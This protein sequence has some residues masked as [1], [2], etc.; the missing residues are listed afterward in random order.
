VDASILFYENRWWLFCGI[1][2]D[3]PNE[4][5]HIFYADAL[6]GPYYPHL[7]NPVK[8]S[9]EGSRMGGNFIRRGNEIYRP[10]QYSRKWYG[11]KIAWWK[12]VKLTPEVF[13]EEPVGEWAPDRSWTFSDGLHTVSTAGDFFAID[14]KKRRSDRVSLTAALR[15]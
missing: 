3:L 13:E 14:A 11:E 6:E 1:R 12:I 7:L 5:L 2:G 4:K 10:G 15:K 8:T 9:P